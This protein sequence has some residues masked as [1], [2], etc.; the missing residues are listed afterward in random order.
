MQK[1]KIVTDSSC[2]LDLDY[3]K[4]LNVYM[5]PL[6]T[7]FEDGEFLDRVEMSPGEFYEK[8][9]N[10]KTLPSTSQATPASFS[11]KFKEA[12][13]EGMEVL[14]I[15]FSSKLSGTYQS[16][17]IAKE[18]LDNDERIEVIDTLAASVGQGLI[19]EKAALMAKEG[20]SRE[21]ISKEV[22]RMKNGM[23]HII[24]VGSLEMLK[25]GGRI[26]SSQAVIGNLLNVKPILQFIDGAIFPL[27]KTRGK[28]GIIKRFLQIL[29]E[30]CEEVK[31]SRIGISYSVDIEF[32]NELKD[33]INKK[34]GVDDFLISEIGSVIGSH[35]GPSTL[36]LFFVGK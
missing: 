34:F 11:K 29:E 27:D 7:I 16:A 20:K 1:V 24:G 13:D 9:K 35:V 3:L 30:R 2:D 32:A 36:A 17:L 4:E 19:V 28:K 18:M 22:I 21:E 6:I 33:E 15:A 25:L 23:Q 26:S 5:S 14:C 31:N 12:L 8:L 10:I